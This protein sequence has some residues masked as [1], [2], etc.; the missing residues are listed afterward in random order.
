MIRPAQSSNTL[1]S[2]SGSGISLSTC[3]SGRTRAFNNSTLNPP[4]RIRLSTGAS[5]ASCGRWT[6]HNWVQKADLQPVNGKNPNHIAVDETAIQ[7][8]VHWFWLYAAL[9]HDSNEFS[10]AGL[11]QIIQNQKKYLIRR[12]QDQSDS[13]ST[14]CCQYHEPVFHAFIPSIYYRDESEYSYDCFECSKSTATPNKSLQS[15]SGRGTTGPPW[16]VGK[17]TLECSQIALKRP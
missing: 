3:I 12:H 16:V 15:Q 4:F 9:D 1:Q 5:S 2:R 13:S 10:C 11:P 8:N 17:Q 7:L 6:H 14:V